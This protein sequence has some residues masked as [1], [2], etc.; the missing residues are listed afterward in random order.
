MRVVFV[1]FFK[2]TI[3]FIVNIL[4]RISVVWFRI[5][6]VILGEE[7]RPTQGKRPDVEPI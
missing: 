3:D 2:E 5:H 7:K 1:K 4:R 6:S